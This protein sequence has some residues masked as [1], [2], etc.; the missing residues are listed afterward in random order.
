MT[1]RDDG[2]GN[3]SPEEQTLINFIN[4]PQHHGLARDVMNDVASE[5]YLA[6][7]VA[8]VQPGA[9]YADELRQLFAT[10]DP[11]TAG[12][13]PEERLRYHRAEMGYRANRTQGY[14]GLLAKARTV[15]QDFADSRPKERPDITAGLVIQKIRRLSSPPA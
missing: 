13:T 10:D 5:A 7:N 8:D 4:D 15:Y 3:L 11:L 12:L 6:A 2:E 14:R 1:E 9:P